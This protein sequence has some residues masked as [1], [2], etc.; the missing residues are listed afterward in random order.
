VRSM[1]DCGI[2]MVEIETQTLCNLSCSYCPNSLYPRPEV[3]MDERTL[4]KV[5]SE[6]EDIGFDGRLSFHFY[7]EPLLDERLP[8]FVSEARMR[9][10]ETRIVIYSNGEYLSEENLD[11]L[12]A[13]GADLLLVTRQ[14]R[15][16]RDL[17][18]LDSLTPDKRKKIR[19]QSYMNPDILYT[20]RGGLI[21]NV[22]CP[23][24]PLDGVPCTVPETMLIIT[25]SG[26]VVPCYEDYLE[27]MVMGNVRQSRIQ[28]IRQGQE[29]MDIRRMLAN[30][31]R[32]TLKLCRAC[33]NTEHQDFDQHD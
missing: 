11:K 6:L 31:N 13:A 30:G 3:R 9:L 33:N 16:V 32:S 21:K 19:Y 10:H 8:G 2:K 14:E 27:S 23:D 26:N 4:T 20:N 17:G 25:A 12:L 18:W 28:D 15:A 24:L 5:L 29:F 1:N 7:N 22:P